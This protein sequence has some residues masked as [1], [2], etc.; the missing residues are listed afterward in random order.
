MIDFRT[1]VPEGLEPKIS[2]HFCRTDNDIETIREEV[3]TNIEDGMKDIVNQYY[4]AEV[5]VNNLINKVGIEV[6]FGK[7]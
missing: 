3:I 4:I 6:R 7:F 1:P 2:R 5:E